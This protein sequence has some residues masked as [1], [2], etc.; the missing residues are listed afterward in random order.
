MLHSR[1]MVL[2]CAALVFTA[3]H[4]FADWQ[5]TKWGS[6]LTDLQATPGQNIV[7]TTPKEQKDHAYAF[8]TPLAKTTYKALNT[9]FDVHFLFS[10]NKLNGVV[11]YMKDVETAARVLAALGDQYG[12]PDKDT[13]NYDYQSNCQKDY[14]SWRGDASGNVISFSG[15]GCLDMGDGNAPSDY[16]IMYRPILETSKTGL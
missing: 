5:Y 3:P 6:N 11:L 2:A 16:H 7:P 10:D 4:A 1:M 9:T 12:K 14:R 13:S 15:W 8:G